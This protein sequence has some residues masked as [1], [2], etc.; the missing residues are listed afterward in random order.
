MKIRS[1]K[2]E[3]NLTLK[4]PFSDEE[5]VQVTVADD[6]TIGSILSR[7]I[8]IFNSL[9]NL[10]SFDILI[11][12]IDGTYQFTTPEDTLGMY[13]L[14]KKPE[15][16]FVPKEFDIEVTP[17]TEKTPI[18]M[19]VKNDETVGKIIERVC[20]EKGSLKPKHYVLTHED[21]VLINSLSIVEQRPQAQKLTLYE[22]ASEKVQLNFKELYLRGPVF[23][24]LSDAEQLSAYLLQAT[25]GPF[26]CFKGSASSLRKFL[27]L[28]FR[29]AEHGRTSSSMEFSF[30]L[31]SRRSN[32][33]IH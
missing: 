30:R 14:F 6:I 13:N 25:Q 10:S 21:V 9:A 5:P 17:E 29:E 3:V 23:L 18:K 31:H 8:N 2:M 11:L 22:S 1:L 26:R 15:I 16:I 24:S 28:C 33:K 27:P 20:K 32:S 7:A 4:V 12:L 19:T